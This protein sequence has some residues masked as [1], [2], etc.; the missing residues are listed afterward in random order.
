LVG[1]AEQEADERGDNEADERRAEGRGRVLV[2]VLVGREKGVGLLG[3][4]RGES[5]V[6]EAGRETDEEED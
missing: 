5:W 3:R 4:M 1:E 2:F 6:G